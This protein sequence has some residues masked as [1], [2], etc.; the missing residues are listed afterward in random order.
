MSGKPKNVSSTAHSSD[1]DVATAMLETLNGITQAADRLDGIAGNEVRVQI[2]ISTEEENRA[3]LR[4]RLGK[5]PEYPIRPRVFYA[6]AQTMRAIIERQPSVASALDEI[7]IGILTAEKLAPRLMREIAAGSINTSVCSDMLRAHHAAQH[8]VAWVPPDFR[9]WTFQ[10]PTAPTIR[11]ARLMPWGLSPGE[12]R[13]WLEQ[14]RL[15]EA[16]LTMEATER[17]ADAARRGVDEACA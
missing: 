5:E 13:R 2:S 9:D 17:H 7:T 11:L 6:A 3:N 10:P 8:A 15:R 14:H 4:R 12:A 1:K 16:R